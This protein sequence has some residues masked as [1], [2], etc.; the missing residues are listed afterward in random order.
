MSARLAF[1]VLAALAALATPALSSH[2]VEVP[3]THKGTWTTLG[4]LPEPALLGMEPGLDEF[5]SVYTSGSSWH[6]SDGTAYS[7]IPVEGDC[8]AGERDDGSVEA[9]WWTTPV[10]TDVATHHGVFWP[11]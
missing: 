9:W 8:L 3:P 10:R 6:C 11:K 5:W 7:D 2:K 1:V 4:Q